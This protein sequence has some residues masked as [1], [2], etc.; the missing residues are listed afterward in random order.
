MK[1]PR[2]ETCGQ[3]MTE[4]TPCTYCAREGTIRALLDLAR[5][6]THVVVQPVLEVLVTPLADF[7]V[8]RAGHILS[9]VHD[10]TFECLG[11]YRRA[12]DPHR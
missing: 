3:A 12:V 5:C 9:A 11:L 4:G 7:R 8:V 10:R 6:H 2:C 1:M